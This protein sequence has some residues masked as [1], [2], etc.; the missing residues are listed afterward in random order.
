VTDAASPGPTAAPAEPPPAASFDPSVSTA[1]SLGWRIA[2]LYR[3]ASLDAE[4]RDDG[5][6]DLPGPEALSGLAHTELALDLIEA[7]LRKLREQ[8]GGAGVDEM[9]A[10]EL[11]RAL[12]GRARNLRALRQR[13]EG[14]HLRLL[15]ALTAADFRL[16][17]AYALGHGLAETCLLP[18]DRR[19]FDRA[20]GPRIVSVKNWLADL[21]SVLPPHASRAVALS[22]R[23]WEQWA[24][25][26]TQDG[27]PIDWSKQGAGVRA[28]LRRQGELWRELLAAEK[29]APDMLDTSHYLRAA[30]AL[31]AALSSSLWRFLRPLAIPLAVAVLLLGGGVALLLVSGT[32]GQVVGA[33]AAA[34]G[35]VGIT[36]AGLRAR[37]GKAATYLENRLWGAEMDLAI[38]EAVLIGP[39]GWGASVGQ[40]PLP[41]AGAPPRAAENIE[42]LGEFRDALQGKREQE[43]AELLAADAEFIAAGRARHGRDA[44]VEWLRS[45]P[46]SSRI[47]SE[48]QTVL[49]ARPG[50]LVTYVEAGADVWRLQEGM[51]RRWQAFADRDEARVA[52]GLPPEEP[53]G[54]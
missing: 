2:A 22:L 27:E 42:T 17:K 9:A 52:A 16:G 20:F 14:V 5:R 8:R 37:L 30:Q 18:E 6:D 36:G 54:G 3:E 33:I 45:A 10:K 19:S 24:A 11:R 34:A 1:F 31:V 15:F 50:Y 7:D 46:E 26:P 49:A 4:Q 38:A 48:P 41:A 35:A 47:A 32:A 12:R 25:E 44:V 39:T 40:V 13:V 23:T 21:A 29:S 28:A 43:V 51:I 53:A